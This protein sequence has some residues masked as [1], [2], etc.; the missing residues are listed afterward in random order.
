MNYPGGGYFGEYAEGTLPPAGSITGS[1]TLTAPVGAIAG[2]GWNLRRIMRGP[3]QGGD[4]VVTAEAGQ[5]R[6]VGT[7]QARAVVGTGRVVAR[8]GTVRG[9][10]DVSDEAL[11]LWLLGW[12]EDAA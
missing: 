1:G 2:T 6:A 12:E 7:V 5:V 9:A 3:V 11:A 8:V 10:G 4:G